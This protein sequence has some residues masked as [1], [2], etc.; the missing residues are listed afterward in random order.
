[1]LWGGCWHL[2]L[3]PVTPR[4]AFPQ[5]LTQPTRSH[6]QISRCTSSPSARQACDSHS[7]VGR[8]VGFSP[9]DTPTT[10]SEL[11]PCSCGGGGSSPAVS[12]ASRQQESRGVRHRLVL[13]VAPWWLAAA[14]LTRS[15]SSP[16]STSAGGTKSDKKIRKGKS[17][18]HQALQF[19]LNKA[20]SQQWNSSCV[21]VQR[22]SSGD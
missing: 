16:S 13:Q 17:R 1:M 9:Q 10:A 15:S 6:L 20:V 7:H 12:A 8:G 14:L 18:R 19:I 21:G 5:T 4:A 2:P 11:L 3:P 22:P